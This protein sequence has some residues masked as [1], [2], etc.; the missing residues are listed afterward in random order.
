LLLLLVVGSASQAYIAKHRRLQAYTTEDYRLLQNVIGGTP[1]ILM[2]NTLTEV[3]NLAAYIGDPAQTHIFQ[4]LK[5][6]IQSAPESYVESRAACA[7]ASFLRLGLSDA[8]LMLGARG[9]ECTL[10]T[11]DLDLYL[12]ASK[13]GAK[14]VNFNHLRS[15]S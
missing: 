8:A 11:A 2:P 3:S 9:E 13:S 14:A 7:A 1:I 10:L 15:F 4:V 5:A 12:E 6:V